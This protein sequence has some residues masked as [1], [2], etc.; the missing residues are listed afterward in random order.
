MTKKGNMQHTRGSLKAAES[1]IQNE[2]RPQIILQ[3][4]Y[5]PIGYWGQKFYQN[6]WNEIQM[7]SKI[8]KKD[9]QKDT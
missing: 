1:C 6:F 3:L 9:T 8:S 4:K 2:N 5:D 7:Y